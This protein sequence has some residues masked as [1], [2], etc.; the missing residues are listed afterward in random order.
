M[1]EERCKLVLFINATPDCVSLQFGVEER[2]ELEGSSRGRHE[3]LPS[4]HC[5]TR[6]ELR[7]PH[8]TSTAQ[9]ILG[10]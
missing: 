10:H 1:M 6:T 3:S 4:P 2:D 8:G 9:S 7:Y 5:T